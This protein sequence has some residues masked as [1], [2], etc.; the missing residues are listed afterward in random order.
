MLI[1]PW[2]RIPQA[3]RRL[4]RAAFLVPAALTLGTALLMYF[5]NPHRSSYYD[6]TFRL[7]SALLHGRLGLN[8]APPPWLNEMAFVDGNYYSGFPLGS[9][10]VMLPFALAK[11]IG[12]IGDYPTMAIAA[13]LAAATVLF[14]FLLSAKYGDRLDRRVILALFPVFGSWLW[15][16]LAFAGTWQ[17]NEGFAVMGLSGA[18]YFTLGKRRPFWAGFFFAVA[19]GNRTE[20]IVTLPIFAYLIVGPNELEGTLRKR[21]TEIA[22]NFWRRRWTLVSFLAVPLALGILTMAHNVARF[23]SPLDFGA[24]RMPGI[25]A[26]PGYRHGIFSLYAFPLNAERM[27]WI[28]WRL[29]P[30]F[31]YLVP[32]GFGSSIFLSCP[33]LFLLFRRGVRRDGV[34]A[35][36]WVA[37]GIL[38]VVLWS[39]GNPGGWQYSYRY[40]VVLLPWIFV[41]L[42]AKGPPRIRALEPA[43]FAL[44]VAINAWGTYLFIW[45][46]YVSR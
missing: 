30:G 15:A 4:L 31:P 2:S 1:R 20:V 23:G 40:A 22:A 26:E 41:I 10:L 3:L 18:L 8:A 37:V 44:S 9:V 25:L 7:A 38:T 39:H 28:P 34:K 27:L 17:I 36:A 42:L 24:T 12:L 11:Q 13:L 32:D 5:S 29:V 43:L 14:L 6:Y 19:F 21:F 46:D 35:A 16:N 45:T 33:F